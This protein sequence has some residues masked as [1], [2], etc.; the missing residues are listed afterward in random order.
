MKKQY[1]ITHLT[2]ELKNSVFFQ[3]PGQA[4]E[5][6]EQHESTLAPKHEGAKASSSDSA[7]PVSNQRTITPNGQSTKELSNQPAQETKQQNTV[8]RKHFSSYLEPRTYKAW[9]L[10]ATQREKKDYEIL[11]EAVEQYLARQADEA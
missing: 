7:K 9:K 10:L 6:I 1:N 4:G 11:Q 2:D 3:T 8:A 5:Q